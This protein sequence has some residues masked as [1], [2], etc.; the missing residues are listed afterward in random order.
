M[1]NS[2]LSPFFKS[3]NRLNPLE[4]HILCLT[5]SSLTLYEE[6]LV[7]LKINNIILA[8]ESYDE[9]YKQVVKAAKKVEPDFEVLSK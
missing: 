3:P 7:Q 4:I 6:K 8:D 2:T 5:N 9:V 1:I